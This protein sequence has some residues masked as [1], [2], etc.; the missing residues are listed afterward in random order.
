[1][2]LEKLQK[3][4]D[5]DEESGVALITLIG[6]SLLVFLVM[7]T[8]TTSTTLSVFSTNMQISQQ[9]A[10]NN[11]ESALDIAEA[12]YESAITY[13]GYNED[14]GYDTRDFCQSEQQLENASF[15][16]YSSSANDMPTSTDAPGLQPGCPTPGD[17]WYLI[18]G[19]GQGNNN[20]E[21]TLTRTYKNLD[22]DRQFYSGNNVISAK[23]V[24]VSST[25]QHN[26][27]VQNA[28]G[29]HTQP[30]IHA[31]SHINCMLHRSYTAHFNAGVVIHENTGTA[32]SN[33]HIHGDHMAKN[34][35]NFTVHGDKC[36][37]SE[38]RTDGNQFSEQDSCNSDVPSITYDILENLDN[39]THNVITL[40]RDRD[41][42]EDDLADDLRNVVTGSNDVII[43]ARNVSTSRLNRLLN[44][45]T[46]DVSSD[47]VMMLN[48][49]T[50]S[51]EDTTISSADY[52]SLSFVSG[53]SMRTT[54]KMTNVHYTG[55]ASGAF[56]N[57]TSGTVTMKNSTIN[58]WI[59]V[60]NNGLHF[61]GSEG[62]NTLNF[63]PVGLPLSE[64]S[65]TKEALDTVYNSADMLYST[66][67]VRVN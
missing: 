25:Q 67:S 55:N 42:D 22:Y 53:H 29:I 56:V 61:Q 32:R 48:R 47:I 65:S 19:K 3:R 10:R 14:I 12:S 16:I 49:G 15:R 35:N 1:M 8:I 30:T 58:G 51:L 57:N 50:Y 2:L 54:I 60:P 31:F 52:G 28:P 36:V 45:A 27:T 66:P 24:V 40:P 39:P 37:A 41:I 63:Y 44:G 18:E 59:S 64:D 62:D 11:A 20:T 6:V 5:N 38:Q 7:A 4:I 23:T 26:I 46:Y 17:N 21:S 43:D 33:C 13:I 9:Q 34:S